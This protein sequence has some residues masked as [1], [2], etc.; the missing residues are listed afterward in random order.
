V[1]RLVEIA[2]AS[3]RAGLLHSQANA[4][5]VTFTGDGGFSSLSM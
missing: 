3:L 5:I 2:A 1:K 4:A